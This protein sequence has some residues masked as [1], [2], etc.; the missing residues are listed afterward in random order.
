[1]LMW[2]QCGERR[3]WFVLRFSPDIYMKGLKKAM[4]SLR[5]TRLQMRIEPRTS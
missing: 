4:T 3:S 1:M 5:I 2:E